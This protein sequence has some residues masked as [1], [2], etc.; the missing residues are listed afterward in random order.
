MFSGK[1][2][3]H[4]EK[5][6]VWRPMVST[7]HLKC[8]FFILKYSL[9]IVYHQ[10]TKSIFLELGYYE[11]LSVHNIWHKIT[12]V[13]IPV[14][15]VPPA[16]WPYPVVSEG[17]CLPRGVGVC[18]GE[19][20]CLGGVCPWVGYLPGGCL[21]GGGGVCPGAGVCPG[22]VYPNMQWGRQPPPPPMNRMTD[23]CW[24]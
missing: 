18:L 4:V 7:L 24:I 17:R 23:Q 1:W 11:N 9:L 12:Q 3:W 20:V 19:G 2:G 22:G 6:Y 8:F 21:S 5:K 10:I 15:C 14:G 13:C 16:C